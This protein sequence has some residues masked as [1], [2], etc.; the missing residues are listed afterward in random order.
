MNPKSGKLD[1]L[2]SSRTDCGRILRGFVGFGLR[3][4]DSHLNQAEALDGNHE[5]QF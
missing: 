1:G 5:E 4:P 2:M 3:H